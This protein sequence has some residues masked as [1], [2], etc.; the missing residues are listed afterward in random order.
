MDA[1]AAHDARTSRVGAV[2]F[3]ERIEPTRPCVSPDGHTYR[4][5]MVMSSFVP[6]RII[7]PRCGQEWGIAVFEGERDDARQAG[8]A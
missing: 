1:A 5:V 2:M 3:Y 7:C 6:R 8:P 4:E